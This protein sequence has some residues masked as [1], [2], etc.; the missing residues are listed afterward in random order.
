MGAIPWSSIVRWAE[1]H[2]LDI[3]DLEVL[4]QHIRTMEDALASSVPEKGNT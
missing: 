2:G 4:E 3:D 1:I